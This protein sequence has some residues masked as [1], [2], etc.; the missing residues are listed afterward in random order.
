[1]KLQ[2]D[3]HILSQNEG[4]ALSEEERASMTYGWHGLISDGAVEYLDAEEEETSMIIMTP[5]DLEEHKAVRAGYPYVEPKD[6]PHRRIK[7][8]PNPAVRTWTH[9][10]IHPAMILGICASII[11]FPDH[12]QSPRNTY[13]SMFIQILGLLL[14]CV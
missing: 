2:N 7:A 3:A 11:P 1:M 12:N 8:K 6:D 4:E 14:T 13:V 10:E 9:C 5:D